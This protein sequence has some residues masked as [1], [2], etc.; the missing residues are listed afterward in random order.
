M[1]NFV[2][3]GSG[4]VST[5]AAIIPGGGST[6]DT[7]DP[8]THKADFDTFNNGTTGNNYGATYTTASGWAT[9][10]CTILAGGTADTNFISTGAST[11]F[12]CLNG[13]AANQG[14]LTSPLLTGGL[15]N[16]SFNYG[17][18]FNETKA[19]FTVQIIQDGQVV[20]TDTVTADPATRHTA[21]EYS[22]D[23]NISGQ[24]TIRI[25]NNQLSASSK[26]NA[27]R[28]AIWNLTWN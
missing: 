19:G 24:F 5:S 7:P 2:L 1:K 28:T 21:F 15:K 11:L 14:I 13:S 4:S 27:D 12:P 8:A 22:H 6:P 10:Q 20:A 23:F 3:S 17:F 25:V 16:L 9:T 26:N 18:P